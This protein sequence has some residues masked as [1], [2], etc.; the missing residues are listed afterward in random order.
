MGSLSYQERSLWGS[1]AAELVVYLPYFF[2]NLHRAN[3]VNKV[4]GTIF[5]IIVLQ[6]LL[7][8][9]IAAA[10]RHRIK[11]ER[12]K[13]IQLR[14]YRAGYLT[15]AGLMVLGLGML[16]FHTLVGHNFPIHAGFVGLHFL[17]VFF[18]MLVISDIVK[19]VTQIVAYRRAL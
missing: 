7:Q 9:I 8:S 3:S 19:T 6:I 5:A 18:G 11:D 4:A 15:L 14:G 13:L 16:W 17:N 2:L 1:L 12:D 10:T